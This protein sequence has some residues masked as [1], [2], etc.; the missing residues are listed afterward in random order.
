M[1]ST[2]ND[3]K[4]F[5]CHSGGAKGADTY[6]EN[7]GE[8]YGVWSK[9][10]SYK[11]AS[12]KGKNKVEISESDFQEGIKKIQ[13][14]NKTLKRKINY[15]FMPLLSRNW[16]QIKNA[17]QIFA[18]SEICKRPGLEYVSGGTGWAVQM[19]IDNKKEVFVF[20]QEQNAWFKWSY[21]KSK[22]WVLGTE[23][24]ITT[25][26]FAGIGIRK[27]KPNGIEAIEKLFESSF[28]NHKMKQIIIELTDKQHLK[29]MEHLR[30]GTTL[31]INAET[32]SGYEIKLCCVD[33]NIS[34]WVEVE[35]NGSIDLGEVYWEI[36]E[37]TV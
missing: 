3:K 27:I 26:N 34:S 35:M 33:G 13:I 11:T 5:I 31:N 1:N 16:Q 12:H 28:Q 17:E 24:L 9:A 32:F 25:T 29:M 19:A 10:Y 22:F 37:K 36:S 7:S 30:R 4:Q 20:D 2:K 15:K 14:A 8:N 23:P 6:F 18:I 21:A